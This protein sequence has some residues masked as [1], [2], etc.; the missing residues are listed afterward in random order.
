VGYE[1]ARFAAS[2]KHFDNARHALDAGDLP[3]AETELVRAVEIIYLRN[4]L[5]CTLDLMGIAVPPRM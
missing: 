4:Q 1:R 3:L 5:T 2:F